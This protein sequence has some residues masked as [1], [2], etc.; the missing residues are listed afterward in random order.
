[1]TLFN[2]SGGRAEKIANFR[3]CALTREQFF[4][5]KCIVHGDQSQ[6]PSSRH[7]LLPR[8]RAGH[9]G[10]PTVSYN[11]HIHLN[12]LKLGKLGW[13]QR[14]RAAAATRRV[15]R[16]GDCVKAISRRLHAGIC[17]C[18]AVCAS[19]CVRACVRVLVCLRSLLPGH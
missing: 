11:V 12:A 13:C 6:T 10:L 1:M 8:P 7:S 17:V 4:Q 3:F 16:L 5:A 14:R 19:A 15:P 2:L 18:A 9:I